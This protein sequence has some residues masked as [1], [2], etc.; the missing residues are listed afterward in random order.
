MTVQRE[1]RLGIGW[2]VSFQCLRFPVQDFL[3]A[4]RV[5]QQ[6]RNTEHTG[7]LA[8]LF[9]LSSDAPHTSREGALLACLKES[10]ERS[11][12][13]RAAALTVLNL[14]EEVEADPTCVRLKAI[15]YN[16]IVAIE[17]ASFGVTSWAPKPIADA[18]KVRPCDLEPDRLCGFFQIRQVRR[19]RGGG[20]LEALAG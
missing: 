15:L 20:L 8:H 18:P 17:F 11:A 12:L 7:K 13:D 9:A 4:L 2:A 6:L 5:R 14:V 3:D 10:S 16:I 1:R 19:Q